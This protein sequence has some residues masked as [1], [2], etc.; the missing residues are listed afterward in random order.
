MP[1]R[2]HQAPERDPRT[3]EGRFLRVLRRALQRFGKQNMLHHAAALTYHSLLALF[4]ALLLGVALFGLLGTSGTL[5]DLARFLVDRGADAQLVDGLLAAGRRAIDARHTSAAA[6]VFAIVFALFVS[7]SA[8]LAATVALNVVVEARDDRS[9]ARRRVHAV[10]CASAVVLLGVGA[11]IAVFLGGGL[12]EEAFGVVGLG[13]TATAIWQVLRFPLAAVLAMTGFAWMYYAAPTVPDPHWRWIS[14]GAAVAV[15]VWLVA[16]FGLFVFA[17]RF[18]TYNATYGAFATAMLLV[19]WLWLSNV[20]LLLGAEVNAA[21]RYEDR[22]ATPISDAGHSPEEA[23][24]EAA[25]VGQGEER[26]G[27]RKR[28]GSRTV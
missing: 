23:Q 5:D 9:A 1:A 24:H 20:A 14:A 10:L 12:A 2:T 11:V 8:F 28:S 18:G 3:R 16:S 17:A 7:S 27:R 25:R 19:V 22:R 4:Q 15:V 13:S 21:G 6:L 26:R